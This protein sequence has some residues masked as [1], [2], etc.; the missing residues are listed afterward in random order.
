M[1]MLLLFR[2]FLAIS[3]LLS[4]FC[5]VVVL[6]LSTVLSF[7]M[8]LRMLVWLPFSTLFRFRMWTLFWFRPLFGISG[9]WRTEVLF[10]AAPPIGPASAW[11]P[12]WLCWAWA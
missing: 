5:T 3:L 7:R 11:V 8:P 6:L 4:R 2:K 12:V 1:G 9:W 10:G